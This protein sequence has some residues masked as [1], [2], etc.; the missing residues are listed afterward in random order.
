MTFCYFLSE[1]Q[2]GREFN[3]MVVTGHS[4]VCSVQKFGPEFQSPA[5]SK[6]VLHYSTSNSKPRSRLG[7]RTSDNSELDFFQALLDMVSCNAC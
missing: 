3:I 6:S 2:T 4:I 1:F 7:P 5:H